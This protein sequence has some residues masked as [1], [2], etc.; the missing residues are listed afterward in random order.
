MSHWNGE[1]R[2]NYGQ[3]EENRDKGAPHDNLPLRSGHDGTEYSGEGAKGGNVTHALML[4]FNL[5]QRNA[6]MDG[7]ALVRLVRWSC[8]SGIHDGFLVT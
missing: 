3:T 4:A 8:R 6:G 5:V 2:T 7:L 1:E